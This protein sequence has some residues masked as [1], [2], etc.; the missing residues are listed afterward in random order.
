MDDIQRRVHTRWECKYHVVWSPKCRRQVLYGRLRQYLGGVLRELARQTECTV[1]EGPLLADH[2]H[3]VLAI[4]P[5][6]AV[7]QGVGCGK[8]KRAIQIART[9]PR[10]PAELPGTARLGAKRLR[11]DRRPRRSQYPRVHSEAT[12]RG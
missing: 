6:Y 11:V 5:K 10:P 9:D 4:P 1:E 8:G 3:M 2:V 7:A 12:G